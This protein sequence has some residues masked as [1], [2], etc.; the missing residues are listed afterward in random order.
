MFLATGLGFLI[1]V[2]EYYLINKNLDYTFN[3][4]LYGMII[5]ME[6]WFS[7][8]F[9]AATVITVIELLSMIPLLIFNTNGRRYKLSKRNFDIFVDID[10]FLQGTLS[11][12]YIVYY[13]ITTM[14]Y[15]A[16]L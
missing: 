16:I 11:T 1:L 8:S 14:H 7:F 15:S 5:P 2:F 10:N 12:I 9:W 3:V 4:V 6:K 13:Q